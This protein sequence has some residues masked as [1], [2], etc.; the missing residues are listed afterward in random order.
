MQTILTDQSHGYRDYDILDNEHGIHRVKVPF[1]VKDGDIINV[2]SGESRKNGFVWKK[3]LKTTL[4]D[5]ENISYL[6][7]E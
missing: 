2:Y 1:N 5:P 6:S 7:S 3:D 4:S